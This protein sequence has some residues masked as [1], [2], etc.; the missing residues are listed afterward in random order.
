MPTRVAIFIDGP[1]TY[2]LA[3]AMGVDLDYKKLPAALMSAGESL[4]RPYYYSLTADDGE[5]EAVVPLLD[6]LEFNGFTLRRLL[7]RSYT[8][9]GTGHRKVKGSV[10]LPL[11]LDALKMAPFYDRAVIVS[12]DG[13]L[14]HLVEA[15]QDAGKHVTV[16]SSIKT[17]PQCCAEEM[18]RQADHFLDL[19]TFRIQLVRPA[20]AAKEAVSA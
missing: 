4:L 6:F 5:F 3:R 13:E 9:Q 16:A 7:G 2:G 15:L 17:T 14:V 1:N 8:D 11:A 20:R 12:G 18:R 19:D 10:I